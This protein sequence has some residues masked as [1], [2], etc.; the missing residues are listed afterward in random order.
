MD[1]VLLVKH[2]PHQTVNVRLWNPTNQSVGW[3][4][5]S[6][7]RNSKPYLD[8]G[9]TVTAS[10]GNHRFTRNK[11]SSYSDSSNREWC[12]LWYEVSSSLSVWHCCF[13]N[14]SSLIVSALERR[15][16]SSSGYG[17]I[18]PLSK[19]GGG[20]DTGIIKAFSKFYADTTLFSPAPNLL[21]WDKI[22]VT[23]VKDRSAVSL[24]KLLLSH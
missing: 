10:P 17:T 7:I 9:I 20:A 3:L 24:V 1:H 4:V 12:L 8:L 21:P 2:I 18:F 13:W 22:P 19:H 5:V 23:F 11:L 15:F 6:I 16:P 14:S